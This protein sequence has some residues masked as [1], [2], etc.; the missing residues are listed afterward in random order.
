M[1][2]RLLAVE[3]RSTTVVQWR[4]YGYEMDVEFGG[5]Y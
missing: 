5:N 2:G 4:W 1:S 3:L